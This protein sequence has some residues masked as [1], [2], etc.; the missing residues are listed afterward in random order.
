[1]ELHGPK[2]RR[3]VRRHERTT[4]WPSTLQRGRLFCSVDMVREIQAT[5][6]NGMARFGLSASC[7]AHRH[8][9]SLLWPTIRFVGK[10]CCSGAVRSGR[11]LSIARRGSGTVLRGLRYQHPGRFRDANTGWPSIRP[12]AERCCSAATMEHCRSVIPGN[13]MAFRGC[14]NHPPAPRRERI[15]RWRSIRFAGR[16]FC[17]EERQI[18]PAE[19]GCTTAQIGMRY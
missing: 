15:M 18:A 11:R 2:W 12:V 19:H 14:N 17:W 13:G 5:R 7:P 4:R 3:R 6:G 8:A 9:P 1:M 10:S 16:H